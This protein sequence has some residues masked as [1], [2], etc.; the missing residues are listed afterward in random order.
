[1]ELYCSLILNFDAHVQDRWELKNP[2]RQFRRRQCGDT[3]LVTLTTLTR[4][5]NRGGD[6]VRRAV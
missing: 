6:S 1:M 4:T 2:G 5:L 3:T